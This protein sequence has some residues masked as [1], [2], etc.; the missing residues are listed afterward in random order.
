MAVQSCMKNEALNI[1]KI[2]LG[3]NYAVMCTWIVV[4]SLRLISLKICAQFGIRKE[5]NKGN[6]ASGS[7]NRRAESSHTM[8]ELKP[9]A[10]NT[11]GAVSSMLVSECVRAC[12]CVCVGVCV[13]ASVC[14]CMC[15]CVDVCVW[16]CV[17]YPNGPIT[18][19]RRLVFLLVS[20]SPLMS[21]IHLST[22]FRLFDF[23]I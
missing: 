13:C 1:L 18:D 23:D 19:L 4:K 12:V 11:L 10:A 20:W 15:L 16:M 6:C 14:V 9:P 21:L 5:R 2:S 17:A 3:F 8:D 22:T 7:G